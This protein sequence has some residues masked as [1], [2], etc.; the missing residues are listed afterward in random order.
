MI[1]KRGNDLIEAKSLEDAIAIF[2]A[3]DGIKAY[4]KPSEKAFTMWCWLRCGKKDGKLIKITMGEPADFLQEYRD[5]PSIVL[6]ELRRAGIKLDDWVSM[7]DPEYDFERH[8]E[9]FYRKEWLS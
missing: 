4:P 9:L 6:R 3:D 8:S 2:K 7:G 1:Y 5:D